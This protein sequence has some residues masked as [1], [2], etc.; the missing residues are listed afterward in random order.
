MKYVLTIAAFVATLW[1]VAIAAI[2]AVIAFAGPHSGAIS[3][4]MEMLVYGLAG[5][6]VLVLPAL[7]A[8]A[9]WRNRSRRDA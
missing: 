7:A 5:L 1:A 3:K 8:R 6:S 4:P 2:F 9:V